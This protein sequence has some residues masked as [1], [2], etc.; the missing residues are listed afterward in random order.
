LARA[1]ADHDGWSST[2]VRSLRAAIEHPAI[3]PL[4]YRLNVSRFVIKKMAREHVYSD[5]GWLSGHRLA[6]KLSVTHAPGARHGSVRFVTGALDRVDSRAA[7]LDLA[8][9]ANVPTLVIYGDETPPK[10]RAEMGA[11]AE[12]P[13]VEVKRLSSGKLAIHEEMPNAVA[14]ALMGILTK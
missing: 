13:N 12:C 3:G 1:I 14:S 2:L 9:H 6:E 7:F 11:L 8:R 5:T 4:L 10:S